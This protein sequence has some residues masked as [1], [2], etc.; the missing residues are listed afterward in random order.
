[1]GHLVR[2][3]KAKTKRQVMNQLVLY[4]STSNDSLLHLCP[5]QDRQRN[6]CVYYYGR[7]VE[8]IPVHWNKCRLS[9]N[10]SSQ[11]KLPALRKF[12][13]SEDFG[14]QKIRALR[15]RR[16]L[17]NSSTQKIPAFR[18]RR[19]SENS[20]SQKIL[21]QNIRALGKLRLMKNLGSEKI[22]AY[23]K[24]PPLTKNSGSAEKILAPPKKPMASS[25]HRKSSPGVALSGL[26]NPWRAPSRGNH[27]PE[28][29]HDD[30]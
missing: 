17:R 29:I 8:Q 4:S 2:H 27:R 18:K 24:N 22:L 3:V 5:S 7:C 21:P 28:C 30:Q 14:S 12:W 6:K 16:L 9:E 25:F 23:G 11:E 13:L 15:K 19:L 20:S 1:M 10:S 26:F